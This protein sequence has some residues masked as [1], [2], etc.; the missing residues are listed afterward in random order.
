MDN[1]PHPIH[2]ELNTEPTTSVPPTSQLLLADRLTAYHEAGHAVIALTQGRD[3]HRVSILPNKTRLGQCDLKKGATRAVKDWLETEV[4]I[5]LAG[6][7]A[8]SR[9]SGKYCWQG[10]ARDLRQVR[11]LTLSRAGNE[12]QAERLERRY[13]EKVEFMLSAPANWLAVELLA[14]DLIERRTVSGRAARYH[15]EQAA[16]RVAK[17]S[18][19]ERSGGRR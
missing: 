15:F 7:A 5:L 3:V 9:I 16:A 1:L 4:L 10:A 12:H 18:A 2:T 6:A 8:E 13:L 11:A 17:Q 14:A 19:A